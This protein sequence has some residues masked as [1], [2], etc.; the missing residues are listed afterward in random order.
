MENDADTK[1]GAY[2]VT[3]VDAGRV[4]LLLGPFINNHAGALARVQDVRTVANEMHPASVF[5]SFGTVRMFGRDS[6]PI[7]SMNNLLGLDE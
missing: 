6:Y 1:D 4:A 2:Y 5:Y 7:G 3:A